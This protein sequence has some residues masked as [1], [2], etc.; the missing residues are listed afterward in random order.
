METTEQHEL[1][2]WY[3]AHGNV[4]PEGQEAAVTGE[5]PPP[6]AVW[7]EPHGAWL[8]PTYDAVRELNLDETKWRPVGVPVDDDLMPFGVSRAQY[9]AFEGAKKIV[10]LRGEEHARLHRWWLRVLSERRLATFQESTLRPIVDA[11]IDRFSERG[12]AELADE[13]ADRVALPLNLRLMAIDADESFARECQVLISEYHA[14]R[15]R[16]REGRV[17][18]IDEALDLA[19]AVRG[20]VLPYVRERRDGTGDDLISLLWRDAPEIFDDPWDEEAIADNVIAMFEGGTHSIVGTGIGGALYLLATRPDLQEEV[21]AGGRTGVLAFTEEALRL[22][23][24]TVFN[25]RYAEVDTELCGAA[26][27][28]GDLV[29]GLAAAAHHDDTH[30][31]CPHQVD[32]ERKGLR[33]HFTF[34]FGGRTCPGHGVA[35]AA[36]QEVVA[37]TVERLHDLRLDPDAPPPQLWHW[38]T[39]KGYAPINVLF[40]SND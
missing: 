3:R 24:P 14:M 39:R 6:Q 10:S 33:D 1:T 32:L 5:A 4:V 11:A 31:A 27:R 29:L 28:T 25:P 35:R 7:S 37:A 12:R 38:G 19:A 16:L 26:V 34:S 8:V 20:L 18:L 22:Y 21:R 13:L 2:W 30:Y 9:L 15:M 23:G 40:S 17:D 36:I